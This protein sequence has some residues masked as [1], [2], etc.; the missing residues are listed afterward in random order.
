MEEKSLSSSSSSNFESG[1]MWLATALGFIVD[2][3]TL[4]SL[5]STFELR[6]VNA[7]EM[8]PDVQ[9]PK[10]KIITATPG[11]KDS[12]LVLIVFS[13]LMLMLYIGIAFYK[14]EKRKF[15]GD[16]FLPHEFELAS[17]EEV[18][19]TPVNKEFPLFFS[20]FGV[21]FFTLISTLWILV[22]YFQNSNLWEYTY[23]IF[24]VWIIG[25][26]LALIGIS[27]RALDYNKMGRLLKTVLLVFVYSI[28]PLGLIGE[29]LFHTNLLSSIL[30]VI[31]I[32]FLSVVYMITTYILT[33]LFSGITL[34]ATKWFY[35]T[36]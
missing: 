32:I 19:I 11:L 18:T 2:T 33:A 3:I 26:L 13:L 4:V 36:T 15:S 35:N 29:W 20:I 24:A 23:T 17:N 10:I 21:S 22:F 12:T 7:Q 31:Q 16:E 9:I 6:N 25:T 1:F 30:A 8:S 34:M 27:L 5:F 14:R 28:L